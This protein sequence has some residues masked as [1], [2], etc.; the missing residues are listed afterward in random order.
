MIVYL[1]DFIRT[2]VFGKIRLGLRKDEIEALGLT[3]DMWLNKMNKETSPIW[4]YGNL[5]LHFDD[6]KHLSGIFNDYIHD[7]QGGNRITIVNHWKKVPTLSDILEELNRI[8]KDYTKQ[9]N[10]YGTITLELLN[11]VY[12]MF[13]SEQENTVET[14]KEDPNLYSLVAFGTK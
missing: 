3:P 6:R 2:G 14:K 4:R 5:E 1:S 10:E 13:E 8:E 9:T 11:R 7:I 12:F